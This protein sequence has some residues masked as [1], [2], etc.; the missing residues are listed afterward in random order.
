MRRVPSPAGAGQICLE[1]LR[2]SSSPAPPV[3]ARE[4]GRWTRFATI[5][6]LVLALMGCCISWPRWRSLWPTYAIFAAVTLSVMWGLIPATSRLVDRAV[7]IS[8][9]GVGRRAAAGAAVGRPGVRVY[10]P[11]ERAE[12]PFGRA[13]VLRGPHYDV[14]VRRGR[15][16]VARRS[17]FRGAAHQ[18]G[19]TEEARGPL[20]RLPPSLSSSY[21]TV[22][23]S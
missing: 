23:P 9:G 3:P 1:R 15:A 13:H 14:G 18:A 22:W 19:L 7:G 12:D 20:P 5:A 2:T 10:R 11:G 4:A 16:E 6:C 21:W 8:L 17:V